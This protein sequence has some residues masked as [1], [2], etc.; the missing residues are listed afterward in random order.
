MIP[1]VFNQNYIRMNRELERILNE[2]PI[3]GGGD[4]SNT[5]GGKT[6]TISPDG[7]TNTTSPDEKPSTTSTGG[8][9]NTTSPD[10][11]MGATST[12]RKPSTNNVDGQGKLDNQKT[13]RNMQSSYPG[14]MQPT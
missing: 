1:S 4:G 7:K 12:G 5:T 6:S 3:E 14:Y 10:G 11:K 2:N 8:K 9:T 13:N